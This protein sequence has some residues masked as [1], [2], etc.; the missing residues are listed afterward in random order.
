MPL[1][2]LLRVPFSP[3]AGASRHAA[4]P[5]RLRRYAMPMLPFAMACRALAARL[6]F[7]RIRSATR[8]Q[9]RGAAERREPRAQDVACAARRRRYAMPDIMKSV[10]H[11]FRSPPDFTRVI[12]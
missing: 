10:L 3:C 4:T 5:R 6:L 2:T 11:F 8:W 7:E 9:K 12:F 1:L